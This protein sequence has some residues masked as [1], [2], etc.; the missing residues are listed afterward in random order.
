MCVCPKQHGA[1]WHTVTNQKSINRRMSCSGSK[2]RAT[3]STYNTWIQIGRLQNIY[4]YEMKKSHCTSKLLNIV[5]GFV[6]LLT[7]QGAGWHTAP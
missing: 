6:C 2:D 3:F 4:H 5:I 1:G 7:Q